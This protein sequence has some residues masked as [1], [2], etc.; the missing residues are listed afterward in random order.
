MAAVAVCAV[1]CLHCVGSVVLPYY[2]WNYTEPAEITDIGSPYKHCYNGLENIEKHA[3]NEI[4]LKIYDMPEKISIPAIGSDSFN[5]VFSALLCDNPDLFFVGR[6][7]TLTSHFLAT[8][9]SIEYIIDKEEY[10]ER[11]AELDGVC[12]KILSSLQKPEDEWQTEKDIHDYIVENCE[13][14][15]VESEHV[16]SSAYGALV[17]GEAACEGYSKAAKLLL[18]MAGIESS[19]VSGISRGFDGEYDPHMW[20]AVKINGNFYYLDCTWDDPVSNDGAEYVTY[21][22]FNVSDDMISSTH[23]DISQDFGCDS[24]EENYYIKTGRY[25]SAYDR[26]DEKKLASLIAKELESGSEVLQ[27]RFGSKAVYD[28][29]VS[30]LIGG[31][32]IYN[33][34]QI[35]K[36]KTDV[37]FSTDSLSY[38]KT[39]NQ[40]LLTVILETD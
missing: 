26:S 36:N 7:C 4:L 14:K 35:A 22:Y 10:S 27:I 8:D 29:A 32:R 39:P 31:G 12:E 1:I 37:R 21:T 13:Y 6:K 20:N 16:Y 2:K 11:K 40:L 30:D 19:V 25:F 5:E 24:T 28:A 17:N 33:V 23:S 34:L 38:Y 3:Y 15:I 9:C 18:D